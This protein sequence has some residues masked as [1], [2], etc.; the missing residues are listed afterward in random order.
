MGRQV[1]CVGRIIGMG[2]IGIG[3]GI[4][5]GS[6]IG[7]IIGII[8]IIYGSIGNGNSS[9][10]IIIIDIW[11]LKVLNGSTGIAIRMRVRT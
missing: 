10:I 2:S 6:S 4:D 11:L 5:I 8:G 7:S 1:V 9:I 3:I